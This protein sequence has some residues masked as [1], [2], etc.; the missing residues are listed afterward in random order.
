MEA[1]Q[2]Q[3]QVPLSS[4]WM[5]IRGAAQHLRVHPSTVQRMV[6]SG[7]LSAYVPRHATGERVGVMLHASQVEE[8]ARA[9][10]ILQVGRGRR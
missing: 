4:D 2:A 10:G 5:T 1:Q 7:V 3:L 9:R 6:Y 8:I